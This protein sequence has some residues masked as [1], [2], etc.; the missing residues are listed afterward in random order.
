MLI[1][2]HVVLT[3]TYLFYYILMLREEFYAILQ[4]YQKGSV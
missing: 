2:Y 1:S 3:K 4:T